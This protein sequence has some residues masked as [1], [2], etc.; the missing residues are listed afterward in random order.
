MLWTLH[1]FTLDRSLI[2]FLNAFCFKVSLLK[3]TQG[4]T[5]KRLYET[6]HMIQVTQLLHQNITA[7]LVKQFCN[8]GVNY[9]TFDE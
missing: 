6:Q 9:I 3:L 4:K 1:S 8:G 5:L 7:T 2:F